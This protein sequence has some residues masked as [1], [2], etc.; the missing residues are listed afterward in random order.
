M[1]NCW[2]P[3][4]LW[5]VWGCLPCTVS[6]GHHEY[7]VYSNFPLCL[8]MLH[9]PTYFYSG[10]EFIPEWVEVSEPRTEQQLFTGQTWRAKILRYEGKYP[11]L[12][13]LTYWSFNGGRKHTQT[14]GN[15][16]LSAK[17]R[18]WNLVAVKWQCQPL[19]HHATSIL[20]VRMWTLGKVSVTFRLKG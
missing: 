10:M 17:T 12:I 18:E 1:R 16:K 6:V 13:H 7:P 14:Q 3:M 5:V 11:P 8:H 9:L 4:D 20:V 2:L 19:S 15:I